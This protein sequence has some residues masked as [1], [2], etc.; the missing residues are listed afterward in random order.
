MR[1]VLPAAPSASRQNRV[2][3]KR[4]HRSIRASRRSADSGFRRLTASNELCYRIA[5]S[6][7]RH[8]EASAAPDFS[9][10]GGIARRFRDAFHEVWERLPTLVQFALI[11]YW[12]QP[13]AGFASSEY[14][15][16]SGP[17]PLIQLVV[18]G[19]VAV[20]AIASHF[21]H[22]LSFPAAI[23]DGDL[24]RQRQ[25]I[26]RVIAQVYRYATGSHEKLVDKLI[27]RPFG[28]W[29]ARQTRP[30]SFTR[31]ERKLDELEAAYLRHLEAE[32]KQLLDSWGFPDA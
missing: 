32:M 20:D 9:A 13:L 27:E 15:A 14:R 17:I 26:A 4:V 18:G 6:L 2:H 28:E 19:K 1:R 11:D 29:E 12:Q 21:G 16:H 3:P 23:F 30:P 22:W 31:R 25:T 10:I 7:P 5:T 8:F 24:N